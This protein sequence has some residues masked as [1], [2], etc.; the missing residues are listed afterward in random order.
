MPKE[1][2]PDGA[3]APGNRIERLFPAGVLGL[4]V[5]G[6]LVLGAILA[7]DAAIQPAPAS[8]Q[9]A[10]PSGAARPA[11]LGGLELIDRPSGTPTYP[12]AHAAS[13]PAHQLP[14]EPAERATYDLRRLA[15]AGSGFTLQLA[16]I[17]DEQNVRR[18]LTAHGEDPRLHLLPT[19]I[20]GSACYRLCWGHYLSR[21]GAAS[22]GTLPPTLRALGSP[23]VILE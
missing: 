10:P 22:A 3:A 2:K 6:V 23:Q 13:A 16:A 7:R 11:E 19:T 18:Q 1:R 20:G 21:D 15:S 5:V 14:Q 17:C 9:L 4:A 8:A 12:A